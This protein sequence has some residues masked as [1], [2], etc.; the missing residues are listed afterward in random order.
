MPSIDLVAVVKWTLILGAVLAVLGLLGQ[1]A[2][3]A[4]PLFNAGTSGMTQAH[5]AP[6]KTPVDAATAAFRVVSTSGEPGRVWTSF[7]WYGRIMSL[8][9]VALGVWNVIRWIGSI[10]G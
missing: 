6:F 7:L 9:V 4:V 10:S 3:N 2:F 1:F 5:E 8:C